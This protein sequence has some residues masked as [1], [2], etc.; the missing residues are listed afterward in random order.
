MTFVTLALPAAS[1]PSADTLTAW[2]TLALAFVALVTLVATVIIARRDA[3]QLR[4]ERTE[5]EQ[6]DHLAEAVAIEVTGVATT[7]LINHGKY[8]ISGIAAKLCTRNN[9]AQDF[10]KSERILGARAAA[11]A[12]GADTNLDAA[13]QPDILTPWDAGMRFSTPPGDI[14]GLTGAFPIVRWTDRWGT[15]WQYQKGTVTAID[16]GAP[17]PGPDGQLS[18]PGDPGDLPGPA[19][20]AAVQGHDDEDQ[21]VLQPGTPRVGQ[22]RDGQA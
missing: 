10:D 13:F 7:V 14:D 5:A 22:Q 8:T 17:W 9:G 18:A 15:R 11:A 12:L 20:G 21:G 1:G 19:E 2:G 6:R 4:A 16:V 3:R